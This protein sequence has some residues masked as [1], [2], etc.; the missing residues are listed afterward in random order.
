MTRKLLSDGQSK[1]DKVAKA[2]QLDFEVVYGARMHL[3]AARKAV[4]EGKN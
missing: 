2:Y 1:M 4:A 3:Q